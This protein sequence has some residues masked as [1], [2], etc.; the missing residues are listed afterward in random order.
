MFSLGHMLGCHQG[1][2]NV[3]GQ[4]GADCVDARAVVWIGRDAE[5]Y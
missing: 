4:M 5:S 1:L 3:S 2:V